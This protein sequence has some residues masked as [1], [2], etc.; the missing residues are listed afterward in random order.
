MDKTDL[1]ALYLSGTYCHKIGIR[2]PSCQTPLQLTIF[3][4]AFTSDVTSQPN[5]M[6]RGGASDSKNPDPYYSPIHQ[7]ILSTILTTQVSTW[8]N[9]ASCS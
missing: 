2:T 1:L 3:G 9:V 8:V 4:T 5:S 6:E 7:Y